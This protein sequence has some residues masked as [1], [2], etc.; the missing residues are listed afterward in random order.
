LGVSGIGQLRVIDSP[1][2]V[3]EKETPTINSDGMKR[4][5]CNEDN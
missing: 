4:T 1:G 5:G 2:M 3:T